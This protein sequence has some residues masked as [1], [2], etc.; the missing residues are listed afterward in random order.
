MRRYG[1][2]SRVIIYNL[3]PIIIVGMFFAGYFI[4]V[5]YNHLEDDAVN[6]A[7][8]VLM[9]LSQAIESPMQRNDQPEVRR[10]ISYLLQKNAGTIKS[11][12]VF[13]A[14]GTAYSV[15]SH[16]GTLSG[17][18]TK[19]SEK[20]RL[21]T[22]V[23]ISGGSIIIRTPI[24]RGLSEPEATNTQGT[25]LWYA[26]RNRESSR[27]V[28][29]ELSVI[30]YIEAEL[31]YS[32]NLIRLYQDT[33][34][35][36]IVVLTG[37]I[38]SL[39]FAFNIIRE[40]VEPISRMNRAIMSIR[41]GQLDTRITGAMHGE[42]E[43]LRSGIN[44]MARAIADYHDEMQNSIDQATSDLN[45]TLTDLENKNAQLDFA[46]RKAR[47]AAR[48]QTEFLA[49]MSHEL[50][51]PLNGVI[52][53]AVQLGK[54]NL[55][56]H[57]KDYLRTIES[58]A[59]H[60]L[61]IINNILDFS[62]LE[63]GRLSFEKIPF[64]LRDTVYD[65]VNLL[66]PTVYEKNIDLSV[67]IDSGVPDLVV[68]D[69]LRL[70]QILTNILGNAVKFTNQGSVTLTM[71][72]SGL[73]SPNSEILIE[74]QVSDTGIG[75]SP[76]QLKTI[77]RPFTQANASIS[78]TFG[79]TGLGLVITAKLLS[80]MGGS[81][82]VK[83]N[84]GKGSRFSMSIPLATAPVE[85]ERIA[86]PARLA[87]CQVL[88]V[89][90]DD[91]SRIS[92]A[93][94]LS[95]IGAS[96]I[97]VQ[98]PDSIPSIASGRPAAAVISL[99]TT[100]PVP[101]LRG[102]AA[103]LPRGIPVIALLNSQDNTVIEELR[104]TGASAV[105]PKPARVTALRNALA[106]AAQKKDGTSAGSVAAPQ[107]EDTH[108]AA[109]APAKDAGTER[110]A[111]AADLIPC[112]VL[113]AD[114]NPANLKLMSIML[115]A[116]VT[117]PVMAASGEEAVSIAGERKLD[118][119]LMDIQMPVMDGVSAMKAIRSGGGPNADTP[120]IAVTALAIPEERRRLLD[121]GMNGF[122]TKPVEEESL[123]EIVKAARK[124]TLEEL[125]KSAAAMPADDM[126][127]KAAGSFISSEASSS[128]FDPAG[129]VRRAA[130]QK[131]I[132]KEMLSL[133]LASVPEVQEAIASLSSV[134][135]EKLAG[136]VHKFAGGAACCGIM[137]ARKLSNTIE[138]AI[139]SGHSP[140]D[141]EPELF[142]LDDMLEKIK[143]GAPKWLDE[144][145]RL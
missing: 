43:R 102:I 18:K 15:A 73:V 125:S 61:A 81:I 33:A 17:M 14:S 121:L 44:S 59:K 24:L 13:N 141:V 97:A 35:S 10:L 69:P 8:A 126:A 28:P 84:I 83:S 145:D 100:S 76:S 87:E 75:I 137:D 36:L 63:A 27:E 11:I 128:L 34:V 30:G 142:E 16:A 108:H 51:T 93:N 7:N 120:V 96:P 143:A 122:L 67:D 22:V 1:L 103:L 136:L 82:T 98:D 40:I 65:T 139:R 41:E 23:A 94:M 134:K 112:R 45:E 123:L 135:P 117:E 55:T 99:C 85:A 29:P 80:K 107:A 88:L 106:S 46:N 72:S 52:G 95:S 90:R 124:G 77:F 25:P 56:E 4:F 133:L 31:D 74:A 140:K 2:R 104:K 49:N 91:W 19:I 66:L 132:A 86:L 138:S 129:A 105:L 20:T 26:D 115:S 32:S 130:G 131:K 58:S 89:D 119:I 101:E 144:I 113:A 109:A 3:L 12:A 70:Q 78:R 5:R 9:P 50:R 54:T 62:K 64:S 38:I 21:R 111:P 47:E 110:K 116:I 42:L 39:V 48:L 37:F 60:L 118:L 71:S 53:F 57:Q 92:Y 127:G 79:G 114:D 68:G 6:R